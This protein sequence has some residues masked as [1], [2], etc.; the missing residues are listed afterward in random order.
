MQRLD[1]KRAAQDNGGALEV[2]RM[3]GLTQFALLILFCLVAMNPLL[4]V[5]PSEVL[6]KRKTFPLGEADFSWGQSLM[7]TPMPTDMRTKIGFRLQTSL[8]FSEAEST[9]GERQSQ[10]DFYGRRVRFQFHST[11]GPRLT[12]AMDIRNDNP[13]RAD[14]GERNFVIGDAYLQAEKLWGIEGL[15]LRL[16]R[17]KVDMSRSQTIGSAD[18]IF[19]DRTAVADF[20]ASFVSD[21]R[22]A[23]NVQLLGKT[24][25]RS[26]S[27]QVVLGDGVHRSGL[28]DAKGQAATEILRQNLMWGA[29]LRWYPVSGWVEAELTETHFGRGQHFAVGLGNFSTAN[30][31]YTDAATNTKE[32]DRSLWNMEL[33]FHK[34]RFSTQWEYF[35]MQGVSRDHSDANTPTGSSD[36]WYGQV[37]YFVSLEKALAVFTRYEHW[38]RFREQTSLQQ[39]GYSLGLNHYAKANKIRYG[40]FLQ[41]IDYQQALAQDLGTN[42]ERNLQV[43]SQWYY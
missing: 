13:N 28:E 35:H 12:Y 2:V 11:F 40:I 17:A 42:Q 15:N 6:D 19:Q 16:F 37:E 41:Q 7:D 14:G 9:S 39:S 31:V 21:S 27:Y 23:A 43:T 22:R 26:L 34:E 3:S 38:D 32:I 18:L 1:W 24:L 10:Q 33:S 36:G 30:I 20:A 8:Q 25:D 5:E 29:K 4:A